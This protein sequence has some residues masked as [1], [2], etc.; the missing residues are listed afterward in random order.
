VQAPKAQVT[1]QIVEQKD[2]IN[3]DIDPNTRFLSLHNQKVIKQTKAERSGKFTNTAQGGKPDEGRK[4][5]DKKQKKVTEDT[6]VKEREPGELPDLKDLS[7]K[8]SMTP[9]PKAPDSEKTAI[10]HRVMTTSKM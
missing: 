5:G 6:V 8:F 4:D 9:G 7:P 2:K 1:D 3:D 10:P